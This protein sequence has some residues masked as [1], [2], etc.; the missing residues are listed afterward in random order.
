MALVA[1]C[2]VG[3]VSGKAVLFDGEKIVS[4]AVIPARPVPVVTAS[5]VLDLAAG[6][7]GVTQAD[8]DYLVGTGYGRVKVPNAQKAVSEITCHAKGAAFFNNDVATLIDVGGQDSK[9]ISLGS[10]GSG[11]VMEFSMN[12]KCAAG[13]GRFLEVMAKVFEIPIEQFGEAALR[14]KRCLAIS[15]QCTV[16][17]ESEVVC[18]IGQ[19]HDLDE[20]IA[21]IC[22]AVAARVATLVGR[23]GLREK[24]YM[25]GGV[26]RNTG[27]RQKLERRLGVKIWEL[28]GD[29]LITGALGAAVMAMEYLQGHRQ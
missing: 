25:S 12:D 23:V 20:I 9:V 28:A 26:A 27:V 10:D 13:T 29:P 18:L 15:S 5:E 6:Q 8:I 19:E 7:A 21:G 3:S 11:R 2:D 14:A 17:A 22:D 4:S 24:V 16:F 1:G